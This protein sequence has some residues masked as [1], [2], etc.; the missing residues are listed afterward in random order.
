MTYG[1]AKCHDHKFDPI[2]QADY[3]RLQAFF[4]NS[5]ANDNIV[6]WP[7]DKVA[8][9]KKKLSAWEEATREIRDQM[10]AMLQPQR[11]AVIQERFFRYHPDIQEQLGRPK[12]EQTPYERQ[13]YA[14][15]RWQ[16]E[17]VTREKALIAKLGDE[18][19]ERYAAL[20]KEIESFEH[21]H[22]GEILSA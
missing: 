10:E 18:E 17:F 19:K 8:E 5:K 3:Y 6:M 20:Q 7:E 14:K 4:A 15:F 21:L 1:C 12:E 11:E 9:H 16:M 2:L 13:M 22:P